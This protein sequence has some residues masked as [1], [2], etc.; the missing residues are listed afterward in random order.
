MK[1]IFEV[2]RTYIKKMDVVIEATSEDHAESEM[3]KAMS[4]EKL[5]TEKFATLPIDCQ[6]DEWEMETR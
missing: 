6:E 3:V 1:Y 5:M 4:N 2:T